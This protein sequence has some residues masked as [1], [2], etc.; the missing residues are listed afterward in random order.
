MA[1]TAIYVAKKSIRLRTEGKHGPRRMIKP[2]MV[3]PEGAVAAKELPHLL[4]DGFLVRRGSADEEQQDEP[5]AHM[6]AEGEVTPVTAVAK[7]AESI[8]TL[9]PKGL[10]GK[11]LDQLNAMILERDP[12]VAPFEDA[13]EARAHLS[14]HYVKA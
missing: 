6:N 4:R 3:L 1:A 7:A 13:K 2:G 10:K 11:T 5:I 8:W 12:A 14:Q 9:D